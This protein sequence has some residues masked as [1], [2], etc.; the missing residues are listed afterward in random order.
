M[1]GDS[2]CPGTG[3]SVVLATCRSDRGPSV[4]PSACESPEEEAKTRGTQLLAPFPD[5]RPC[6][7]LHSVSPKMGEWGKGTRHHTGSPAPAWLCIGSMTGA[8]VQG[9]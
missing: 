6:C 5:G 1:R 9:G 2:E 7:P 3:L 4:A 8:A